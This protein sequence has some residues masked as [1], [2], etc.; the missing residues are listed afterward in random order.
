MS[1]WTI[2]VKVKRPTL[3]MNLSRG[4]SV[5]QHI[6][7]KDKWHS[8]QP[9]RPA[10]TLQ[11]KKKKEEKLIE[12]NIW[13]YWPHYE[14]FYQR[15]SICPH[16]SVTQSVRRVLFAFQLSAWWTIASLEALYSSGLRKRNAV[17]RSLAALYLQV[18]LTS[19]FAAP[20]RACRR[21]RIGQNW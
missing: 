17:I 4:N 9:T 7:N 14:T 19:S 2:C 8:K 21:R 11:K 5:T 20:Q 13:F 16:A 10:R 18:V 1:S 15:V 12:R 6:P 3:Y